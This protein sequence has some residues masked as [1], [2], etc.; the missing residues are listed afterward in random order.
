MGRAT[1]VMISV[2]ADLLARIDQ[3]AR[4]RRTSRSA[5]LQ[6]AALRELGSPDP[7]AIDAALAN[8]GRFES[9]DLIRAGRDAQDARDRGR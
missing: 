5:F 3:A 8:V 1:K 2:P 6:E 7:A 4:E 9:G